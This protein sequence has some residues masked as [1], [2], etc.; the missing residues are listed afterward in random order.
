MCSTTSSTDVRKQGSRHVL[1]WDAHPFNNLFIF[2]KIHSKRR[3]FFTRVIEAICRARYTSRLQRHCMSSVPVARA[4]V[5]KFDAGDYALSCV[6]GAH[7]V[8]H[9]FPSLI[10]LQCDPGHSQHHWVFGIPRTPPGVATALTLPSVPLVVSS[11]WARISL[12]PAPLVVSSVRPR[13]SLPPVLLFVISLIS[14]ASSWTSSMYLILWDSL[15]LSPSIS[16]SLLPELYAF[17]PP[18]KTTPDRLRLLR[19]RDP[20]SSVASLNYAHS[21]PSCSLASTGRPFSIG[22]L[23]SR[24][25]STCIAAKPP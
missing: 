13:L 8:P 21:Q 4:V 15:F 24:N 6:S 19:I 2:L 7:V 3:R 12:S 22:S 14:S 5:C 1:E 10:L 25:P 17:R 16:S 20:R 9:L 23:G 11:A 18:S